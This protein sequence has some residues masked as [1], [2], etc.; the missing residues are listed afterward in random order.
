MLTLVNAAIPEGG[1][2]AFEVKLAGTVNTAKTG[3]GDKFQ[4]VPAGSVE[5]KEAGTYRL[6]VIGVN[7]SEQDNQ[8]MQLRAVTLKTE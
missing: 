4:E 5:I 8:L 7:I 3:S 1:G 6:V 2:G